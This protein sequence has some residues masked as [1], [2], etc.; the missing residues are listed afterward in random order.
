VILIAPP[1][2]ELLFAVE[3]QDVHAEPPTVTVVEATDAGSEPVP[4]STARVRMG[5]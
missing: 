5:M 2:Q 1:G 4:A 3:V